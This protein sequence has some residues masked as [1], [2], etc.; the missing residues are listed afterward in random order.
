MSEPNERWPL[1]PLL[2]RAR[3][4]KLGLM[5]RVMLGSVTPRSASVANHTT[6]TG[7]NSRPT[8]AVPRLWMENGPSRL[9]PSMIV[10]LLSKA[11]AA[12]LRVRRPPTAPRWRG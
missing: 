5:A 2:T 1:K 10:T 11:G 7:P 8:A 3:R 12:L 9:A 4:P 6:I